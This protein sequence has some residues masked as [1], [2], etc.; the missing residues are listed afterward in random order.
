MLNEVQNENDRLKDTNTTALNLKAF[1]DSVNKNG[2]YYIARY[3]ASYGMDGKANSKV[4]NNFYNDF[5]APTIE[6]YLWNNITQINAVT[7]SRNLYKTVNSDLIN[8][9]AYDTAIIYIQEF[10]GDTDYSY[11]NSKNTGS[12]PANTGINEDEKEKEEAYKKKCREEK[13]RKEYER[14]K[15]KGVL[16]V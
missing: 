10:S 5:T 1:I 2:G 16:I 7:A 15:E 8:S 4:S 11:Q 14:L 13:D 3:E 12:N 6:G 9:Y